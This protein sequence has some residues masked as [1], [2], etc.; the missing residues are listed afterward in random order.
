[1]TSLTSQRVRD[2]EH[3]KSERE[4]APGL[5][6]WIRDRKN[7]LPLGNFLFIVLK[8]NTEHSAQ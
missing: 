4:Q 5:R 1:M 7:T 8:Q 3:L 6:G 2:K